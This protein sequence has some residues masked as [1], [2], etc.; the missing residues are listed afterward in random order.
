MLHLST[1]PIFTGQG[2]KRQVQRHQG[3]VQHVII[4]DTSETHLRGLKFKIQL[5]LL[6]IK[7]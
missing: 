7:N 6:A 4:E 5:K 1:Q 3:Q 2:I